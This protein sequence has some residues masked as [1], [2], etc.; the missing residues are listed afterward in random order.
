MWSFCSVRAG[1][2]IARCKL[3]VVHMAANRWQESVS[4]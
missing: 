1:V 4:V 3:I 2:Y